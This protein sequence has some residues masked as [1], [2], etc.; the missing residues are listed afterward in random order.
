MLHYLSSV[1]SGVANMIHLLPLAIFM[2]L[3]TP[4]STTTATTHP[5]VYIIRHGEQTGDPDDHGLGP[6]GV[7][8]AQCLR[9]VFGAES[10]YNI[11]YIVAPRVKWSIA[12][13][14][15]L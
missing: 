10:P 12:F 6:L 9:H 4:L 3:L 14:V 1:L 13:S 8:R 15:V 11:G 5:T 2:L 7:K